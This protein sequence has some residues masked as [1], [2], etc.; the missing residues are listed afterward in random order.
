[1]RQRREGSVEPSLSPFP[2]DSLPGLSRLSSAF[3]P[4]VPGLLLPPR[5]QVSPHLL[6]PGPT[7][8]L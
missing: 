8:Q 1:M 4:L 2:S 5:S 6:L 3:F 7:L